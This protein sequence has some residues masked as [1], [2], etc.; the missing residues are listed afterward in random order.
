MRCSR[1]GVVPVA[2]RNQKLCGGSCKQEVAR[3]SHTD[4]FLDEWLA[5]WC[6]ASRRIA[7]SRAGFGQVHFSPGTRT[8]VKEKD[9]WVDFSHHTEGHC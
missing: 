1:G 5:A 8:Y 2:T 6:P 4:D 7:L 3:F 9:V